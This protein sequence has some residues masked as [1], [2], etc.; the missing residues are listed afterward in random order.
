MKNMTVTIVLGIVVGLVSGCTVAPLVLKG[1]GAIQSNAESSAPASPLVYPAGVTAEGVRYC[2]TIAPMVA[3]TCSQGRMDPENR[4]LSD[5]ML[6]S[7][8]LG[9]AMSRG[10]A[11]RH[12]R[13]PLYCHLGITRTTGSYN[14]LTQKCLDN[15]RKNPDSQPI[16]KKPNP[17]TRLA[18]AKQHK[19]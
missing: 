4:H 18:K 15:F 11:V 16:R 9:I 6:Q 1:M 5:H 8:L 2:K 13:E 12:D 14:E 17:K 7:Q 10:L 3:V 19:A